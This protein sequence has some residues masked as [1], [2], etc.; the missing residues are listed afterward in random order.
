MREYIA[1]YIENY[2][3]LESDFRT[4]TEQSIIHHFTTL[5]L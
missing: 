5:P 3:M 1:V 4:D 2:V